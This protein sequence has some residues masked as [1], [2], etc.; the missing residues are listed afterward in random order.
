ML[1]RRYRRIVKVSKEVPVVEIPE[2]NMQD[3]TSVANVL[4]DAGEEKTP[5]EI[6]AET[7]ADEEPKKPAKTG[8]GK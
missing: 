5:V 7:P 6:P 1:L 8:K 3:D 4:E 2:T